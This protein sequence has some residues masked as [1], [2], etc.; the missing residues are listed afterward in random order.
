MT[1][2]WFVRS[3][4]FAGALL[5][6]QTSPADAQQDDLQTKI[7]AL[8][9]DVAKYLKDNSQN[10]IALGDFHGAGGEFALSFGAEIQ[11]LLAEELQRLKIT[12]TIARYDFEQKNGAKISGVGEY[13]FSPASGKVTIEMSL[14]VGKTEVYECSTDVYDVSDIAALMGGTGRLSIDP[15]KRQESLVSLIQTPQAAVQTST[16]PGAGVT[17]GRAAVAEQSDYA[18]E[19]WR[20]KADRLKKRNPTDDDYELVP[21]ADEGGGLLFANLDKDNIYAI[22]LINNT[23]RSA[24]ATVTI[25]GLNLFAFSEVAGYRALGK[26]VIP[27]RTELPGGVLL[28]GWHHTNT[29]SYAF[30]VCDVGESAVVGLLG[31]GPHVQDETGV[32]TVLF[33][34]AADLSKDETLPEDEPKSASLA[35]KKGPLVGQAY[36][37]KDVHIG[38]D[39]EVISVRYSHPLP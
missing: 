16:V 17:P 14:K 35:T 37:E 7:R 32:I 36:V 28:K 27:P 31:D 38:L 39:R 34:P 9:A 20:L 11:R 3:L 18:M 19:I 1:G 23:D 8:A 25:D 2:K 33:A 12:P 4:I 5:L 6:A 26:V 24:A 15:E 30:Q 22:R 29:H 21:I 13:V 10:Q